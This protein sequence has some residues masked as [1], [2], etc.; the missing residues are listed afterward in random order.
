MAINW[1]PGHMVVA[2][3]KAEEQLAG[4]DVVIEVLDARCPAATCNPVID[5]MRVARQRPGLKIINKI[6]LADSAVTAQWLDFFN[7]QEGVTAIGL[8][9]KKAGESGKVLP[10]AKKLAPTRGTPDKR[11]RV[12]MMGVPNVGKSTLI[13]ALLNRRI[14]GVG[15]EPAVTKLI[16]RYELE[17]GTWLID[18]PGLMWPKIALETDGLLL[19]A[20][21]LVG[22]NA[23]I[24]EEVATYL[25][26]VLLSRY[27]DRLSERYGLDPAEV[28][29]PGVI[30]AI[31]KRRG[32]R[33]KGGSADYE[34]A[35]VTLLNDYRAGSLGRITLE[36][37]ETR[38]VQLAALAERERAKAE[39]DAA[40]VREKTEAEAARLATDAKFRGT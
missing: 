15:D 9:C 16:K 3:R 24:D 5:A 2:S 8:S 31:A 32:F 10:A 20:S 6:D 28:D 30:E 1:Y 33:I 12:M 25:A 7:A 38:G 4:I 36:T 37:P 35:A 22:V 13:N 17:D 29:G 40:A 19:A 26:E 18:T 21:H 23:Y 34:K 27:P 11:L 14:A 39:A